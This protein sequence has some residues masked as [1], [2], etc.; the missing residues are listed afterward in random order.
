MSWFD[1]SHGDRIL[2]I[3]SALGGLLGAAHG[4][5]VGGLGGAI[6]FLI[7]GGIGGALVSGLVTWIFNPEAVAGCMMI[8]A[9]VAVV[10]IPLLIIAAI[11]GLWGVGI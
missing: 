2:L 10:A 4:F 6:L 3:F 11:V 7:V 9:A 1:E 8:L 5:S